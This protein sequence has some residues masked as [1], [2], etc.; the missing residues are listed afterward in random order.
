LGSIEFNPVEILNISKFDLLIDVVMQNAAKLSLPA[1]FL[2]LYLPTAWQ[3]N[4][5]IRTLILQKTS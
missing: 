4:Q 2:Q 1:G 5:L 3:D